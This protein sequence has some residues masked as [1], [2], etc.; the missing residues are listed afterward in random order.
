VNN[1]LAPL[2]ADSVSE[3]R[4]QQSWWGNHRGDLTDFST[5]IV[6]PAIFVTLIVGYLSLH[7]QRAHEI[8]EEKAQRLAAA[9]SQAEQV[10]A[11]PGTGTGTWPEIEPKHG[12]AY[13]PI[14]M[15]NRSATPVYN[16]V[17]TLVL[18]EGAG[19]HRAVELERQAQ[20]PYQQYFSALPPGDYEARVAAGWGGMMARPGVEI[21]FRDSAGRSWVRYATGELA[22]LSK[23]PVA[24]YH[25]DEPIGWELPRALH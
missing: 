9:R 24:Y 21:A 13:T 3:D 25:L 7:D 6:V 10:S 11:V 12:E 20:G 18:V 22:Q 8:R 17:V 14:T 5:V 19:A 2:Y 16:V 4:P 23:E 15:S 1:D